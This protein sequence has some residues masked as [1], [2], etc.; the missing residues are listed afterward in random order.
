MLYVLCYRLHAMKLELE[1]F[2]GPLEL[3][4]ELLQGQK[5]TITELNLSEVTEQFLNFLDKLEDDPL[6]H[7]QDGQNRADKL[8][9]FLVV[10]SRL[11]LLKSKALLPQFAPEEDEGPSLEDQLR[12]YKKFVEAS[13]EL[14]KK[15]LKENRSYFRIE[16]PRKMTE[17]TAPG[18]LNK[19][20]ICTSM[21]QLVNRLKPVKELPTTKIDK[22]ISIKQK[23]DNIRNF[24]KKREKMS[25]LEVVE[26]SKNK[27]DVI[28]SFL[29]VLELVKQ[30]TVYLQQEDN[31]SDI[32]IERA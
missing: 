1:K 18:N 20:A 26:S 29:A 13:K 7:S 21:V 9:D 23:I 14:N 6:D 22:T 16:P 10:G 32:L 12:L 15:W 27:T 30:R 24:L 2:S 8:A 11:L 17:F 31:F 4:L 25:F 3:L 19:D 28:T 5:L